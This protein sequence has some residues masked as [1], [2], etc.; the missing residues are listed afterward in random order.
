M[1]VL[2]LHPEWQE[3][4]REEVLQVCGQNEPNF[5]ALTHLKIVNMILNEVL[6]LYP[7][8]ISLCQH[9]YKDTGIGNIHLPAGVDLALPI[10]LI[11]HDPEPWG[12]DVE[13][14][15]PERF[16]G[17]VSRASKEQIALFPFGWS[18]R[19]C[20]GQKVCHVRSQDGF[21]NDSAEFRIQSLT[22]LHPCSSYCYDTSTTAWCSNNNTSTLS[23][24]LFQRCDF[25]CIAE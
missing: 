25:R 12:D 22:F 6:R 9:T 24:K 7:P 4:A 14:F 21:G 16:L 17:G 10:L 2:A 13:E 3:M 19:T 15:R 1:M 5:E 20:I 23:C 11:H 18:L 8:V